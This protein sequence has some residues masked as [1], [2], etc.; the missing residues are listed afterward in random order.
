MHRCGVRSPNPMCPRAEASHRD[1]LAGR[2]GVHGASAGAQGCDAGTLRAVAHK[3]GGMW[4]AQ[5]A[6]ATEFGWVSGEC[7][8][9]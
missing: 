4:L 3:G 8:D 2:E 1:V 9:L 5:L 7:L 6:L